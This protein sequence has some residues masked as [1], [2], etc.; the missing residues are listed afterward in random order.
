MEIKKIIKSY[1]IKNKI[2]EGSYSQ[3][4]VAYNMND[5]LE[6]VIKIIK[7]KN[8]L[9]QLQEVDLLKNI[10]HDNI[11]QFRELIVENNFL[12]IVMDFADGGDLQKVNYIYSVCL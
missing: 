4:Y 3:V 11:I 8:L 5:N 10:R 6:Y 1:L 7:I 12:Y 2:G 9:K